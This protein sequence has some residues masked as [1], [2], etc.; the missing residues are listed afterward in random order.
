[1]KGI[2]QIGLVILYSGIAVLLLNLP[3]WINR[4]PRIT[5]HATV[6]E[7]HVA[8]RNAYL[9]SRYAYVIT[10]LT[11][12]GKY[13]EVSVMESLYGM[14]KEGVSGLLTYQGENLLEFIE[15]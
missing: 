1:M 5:C 7:K 9:G 15:D 8:V 11:N 13:V 14:Y 2:E 12:E 3:Y 4:K 10:F 6:K